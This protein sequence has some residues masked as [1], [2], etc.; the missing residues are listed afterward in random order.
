[1][2]VKLMNLF[3]FN[4]FLDGRTTRMSHS[5]YVYLGPNH[6]SSFHRNPFETVLCQDR[7]TKMGSLGLW[8]Y[9]GGVIHHA[10]MEH[11]L[12]GSAL[13]RLWKIDSEMKIY[14]SYSLL[15]S[16]ITLME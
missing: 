13:L 6:L 5:V 3:N 4:D 10:L 9:L 7:N 11:F 2:G 8:V 12:T 15:I 1:M 14:I 16:A